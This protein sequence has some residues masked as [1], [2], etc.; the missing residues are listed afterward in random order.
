MRQDTSTSRG[1]FLKALIVDDHAQFR[2]FLK[3]TLFTCLPSIEVREAGDG[4]EALREVDRFKPE[5][6]LMDVRLPGQSGLELT[7]GIKSS[8]PDLFI[9]I[10]TYHHLREYREAA[11]AAGANDFIPKDEL[12]TERISVLL[13][14]VLAA[15]RSSRTKS[16]KWGGNKVHS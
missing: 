1:A 14:S 8:R 15:R 6:I 2:A 4:I 11:S 16:P 13:D 12:S 9:A 5:L 3:H 10:V 7:K